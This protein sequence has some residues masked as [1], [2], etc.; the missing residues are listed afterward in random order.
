MSKNRALEKEELR[1]LSFCLL[2]QHR[3]ISLGLVP[4]H[5]KCPTSKLN[6]LLLERVEQFGLNFD[7]HIVALCDDS[8]SQMKLLGKMSVTEQQL[9]VV[10]GVH[11]GVS[12]TIYNKTDLEIE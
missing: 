6:E 11:L 7:R 12:K 4:I 2:Q 10:H 3:S 9:C 5:G 1:Y 8:C